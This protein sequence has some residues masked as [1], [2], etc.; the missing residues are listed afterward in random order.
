MS[1]LIGTHSGPI[2]N[3]GPRIAVVDVKAPTVRNVAA[4]DQSIV[5][6][7]QAAQDAALKMLAEAKNPYAFRGACEIME[8]A[9]PKSDSK[10]PFNTAKYAGQFTA[11]L[12]SLSEHRKPEATETKIAAAFTKPGYERS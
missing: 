6:S 4:F 11:F 2:E 12:N 9:A 5:R 3:I 10:S 1:I 8:C 7:E